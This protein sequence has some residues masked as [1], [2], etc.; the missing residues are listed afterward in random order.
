MNTVIARSIRV[1]LAAGVAALL[2]LGMLSALTMETENPSSN[3]TM[4][5]ILFP[6]ARAAGTL[7]NGVAAGDTTPTSTVLWARATTIGDVL[8]EYSTD[9]TFGM[10]VLTATA[11]VTDLLQ[12]VKVQIA[13]L[14]PATTYY[15]RVA[16]AGGASGTGRFRTAAAGGAHAGLRFGVSG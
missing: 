9:P 11:T 10:A 16:D 8:F 3:T 12:P 14:G 13:E 7:R 2:L 6:L 5:N 15:Y 4:D 1:G